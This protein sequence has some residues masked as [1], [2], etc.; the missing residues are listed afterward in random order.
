MAEIVR[1]AHSRPHPIT[2]LGRRPVDPLEPLTAHQRAVARRHELGVDLVLLALPAIALI[3]AV[4]RTAVVGP[5]H[6]VVLDD[7][8]AAALVLLAVGAVQAVRATRR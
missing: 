1:A 8:Y 5:E 4:V 6:W 3:V 2:P 7:V